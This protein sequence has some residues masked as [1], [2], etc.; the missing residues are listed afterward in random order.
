MTDG[1][2]LMVRLALMLVLSMA[3]AVPALAQT[4]SAT[5]TGA[6]K[7]VVRRGPGKQF[8][9]F[10]SLTEGSKVEVEQIDGEWARIVTGNGQ[11]GYVHSNFLSLSGSV[12]VATPAAAA[13]AQTPDRAQP[14]AAQ[15]HPTERTRPADAE[16]RAANDRK[17]SLESDLHTATER[18]KALESDLK[19]ATDR[20]KAL[21]V[22]GA[23]LREHV[24]AAEAQLQVAQQELVQLR[25]RP[26]PTISVSATPGAELAELRAQIVR[27]TGAV[28]AL[29]NQLTGTA[30]GIR[31]VADTSSGS[32]GSSE[33]V[34]A[35]TVLI[36]LFGVIVGW[37]LGGTFGRKQDRTRRSR[38]R[39]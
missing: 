7:L 15:A 34:S 9:P 13:A 2:W 25:A 10:A 3:S 35:T 38:I 16:L 23:S 32:A 33:T 11:R 1:A 29:Q 21:E 30:G 24:K 26:E 12:D 17:K 20:S 39:F 18:T 5:V 19:T 6:D 22:E 36:G 27:L 4:S 14:E 37:A 31:P 28:D 8:P